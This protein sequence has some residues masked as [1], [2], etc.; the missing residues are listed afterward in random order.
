MTAVN[1]ILAIRTRLLVAEY[2]RNSVVAAL[3]E[4]E[5]VQLETVVRE[6]DAVRKRKSSRYRRP[7]ALPELLKEA[8]STRRDFH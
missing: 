5:N 6:I 8:G 3:A 4:A 2:G 1:E 7:K